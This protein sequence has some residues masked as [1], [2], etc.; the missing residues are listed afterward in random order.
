MV[1]LH[2]LISILLIII[3]VAKLGC[4]LIDVLH[5]LLKLSSE[6]DLTILFN[7]PLNDRR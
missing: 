2:A 3:I 1:N 4:Y 6:W 5:N 7:L